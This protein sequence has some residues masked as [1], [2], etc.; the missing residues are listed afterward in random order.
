MWKPLAETKLAEMIEE[1]ELSMSPG[2]RR[3]WDC[4]RI[5]PQKWK[6]SPWG[7][8][9]GG[10]WVVAVIRGTLIY[11]NDIEEGFNLSSYQSFGQIDEYWCNQSDLLPAI[12]GFY[13]QYMREI[14]GDT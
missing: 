3:F 13:Q 4:I 14:S 9:S 11:Y 10:F 8:E 6:L 2:C 12:N 1:A 5:K 7:D